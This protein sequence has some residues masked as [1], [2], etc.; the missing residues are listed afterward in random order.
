MGAQLQACGRICWSEDVP[1]TTA[2]SVASVKPVSVSPAAVPE[3]LQDWAATARVK[4]TPVNDEGFICMGSKA[5]ICPPQARKPASGPINL[6]TLQGSWVG[7]GGA[8]ITVLGTEVILNG[9]TLKGHKVELNDDGQV[10]SIGK[11][12]QL[13]GW[14]A[15][16]DIE[17][18]ASSTRENME[19][20]RSE[21]WARKEVAAGAPEL[22][23]KMKL[24]GYAGSC[25]NPLGRGVEGCLPGT[26][27]A[28]MR[29]TRAQDAEDVALLCALVAQWREKDTV[30]V[31]SKQVVPDF[32]NRSQ[33]GLG[34]ELMHYIAKSIRQKGF[35]AR[36]GKDG[37]DIPVVVREPPGSEFQQLALKVWRA[38]VEEE[39]GFPPV[40]ARD[41]EELFTSLGNGHFFQSLNLYDTEWQAIND[42]FR[43]SLGSDEA[44]RKAIQEGVVSVVL[45]HETPKPVRAKIA[46]LLNAKREFQWTLNDDGTV[47]TS[48][49]GEN[50]E[51]CSQFEWLSKGMDAEQVNCLVRTHLGIRDSHRIRG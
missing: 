40:R 24:L 48:N 35:K 23:E 2:S 15:S 7:S 11:L 50:T 4:A 44:L 31:R 30:R 49:M 32:T 47:D 6:S 13:Q 16:G 18:R 26:T 29:T 36:S 51:Y 1:A 28:E 5:P 27:G 41:D 43:Y 10:L 14:T 38:R 39:P 22:T 9:L 21:I 12:W 46:D 45:R 3:E 17:F 20:A 8:A 37:H 25:A 42:N 34:V 19:S 33:T